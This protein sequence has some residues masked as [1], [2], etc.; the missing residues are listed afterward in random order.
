[1][2]S[3]SVVTAGMVW[4]V[5]VL[6][7]GVIII[8]MPQKRMAV[9]RSTVPSMSRYPSAPVRPTPTDTATAKVKIGSGI[10]GQSTSRVQILR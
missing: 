9:Q 5:L 4:L 2:G 10:D 6:F 8:A 7:F 1:M 3:K